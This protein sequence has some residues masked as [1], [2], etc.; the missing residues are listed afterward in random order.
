MGII[1]G[2]GNIKVGRIIGGAVPLPL[3]AQIANA[4]P[5]KIDVTF[6]QSLNIASIPDV[7][8]F[9]LAGKTITNVAIVA[10]VLTLTVSVAYDYGDIVTLDYTK[11]ALNPIRALAGGMAATTFSAMAVTNL[12]GL[13]LGDGNSVVY[14]DWAKLATLTKDTGGTEKV[15]AWTDR[16]FGIIQELQTNAN[17]RPVWSA[18]EGIVFGNSAGGW[19][20]MLATFALVQPIEIYMILKINSEPAYYGIIDGKNAMS[21]M[22]IKVNPV[23]Q[24]F[25]G[26]GVGCDNNGFVVGQ[27]QYYH[28]YFNGAASY[29]EIGDTISA[30][31]AVGTSAMGGLALAADGNQADYFANVSFKDIVVR[32]KVG[33]DTTADR[34]AMKLYLKNKEGLA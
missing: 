14:F 8:A 3:S 29:L 26:G 11:P 28:V 5:T 6:D 27:F 15:S 20:R 7:T 17:I 23:L 1:I 13:L 9:T 25:A 4:T 2:V 10:A 31:G 22:V 32:T 19:R 12:V 30:T 34:A 24:L 33:G 21:G 18:T 16:L